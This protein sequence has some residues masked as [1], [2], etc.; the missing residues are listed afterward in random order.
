MIIQVT[1]QGGRRKFRQKKRW[2]DNISERTGLGLNEALRKAGDRG[3]EK[4][5]CPI[6]LDPPTVNQTMG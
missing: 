5:G 4:S 3:M 2:K 6:I 1:V